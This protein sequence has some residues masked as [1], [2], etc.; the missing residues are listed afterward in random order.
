MKIKRKNGRKLSDI[1]PFPEILIIDNYKYNSPLHPDR[2]Y[3]TIPHPFLRSNP[4]QTY[5]NHSKNENKTKKWTQ[6]IRYI[7]IP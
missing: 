3:S 4:S 6:A 5:K 2:R 1:F 7:S